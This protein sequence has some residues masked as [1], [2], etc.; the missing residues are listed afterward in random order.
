MPR[1][2]VKKADRLKAVTTVPSDEAVVI[3]YFMEQPI[4]VARTA[5]RFAEHVLR[6]RELS[7]QITDPSV[8]T[9]T[10]VGERIEA[11]TRRR[12]RTTKG[13][14]LPPEQPGLPPYEDDPAS[15]AGG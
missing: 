14:Q 12:R 6:Q 1:R 10:A 15:V 5:H 8:P 9:A 11:T 13:T 3:R 7:Q 2:Y 4:D